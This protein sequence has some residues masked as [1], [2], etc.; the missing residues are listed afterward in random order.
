MI[1]NCNVSEKTLRQNEINATQILKNN[2]TIYEY[3]KKIF[4]AEIK[5]THN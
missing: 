5:G 3:E 1:Q 2:P 4:R